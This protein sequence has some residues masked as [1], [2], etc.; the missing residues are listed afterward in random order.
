[1]IFISGTTSV[2]D[3]KVVGKGDIVAQTRESLEIIKESIERLG[4]TKSDIVRT[5]MFV[6]DISKGNLIG[7]IHGEFFKGINPAATMVEVKR[8]INDDLL[9]EIEADAILEH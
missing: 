9:I 6:T 4:G 1:M 2:R 3:G 5:R 7:K 8:L